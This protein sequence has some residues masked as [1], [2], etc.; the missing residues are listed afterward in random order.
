MANLSLRRMFAAT[1]L[2]LASLFLMPQAANA[3]KYTTGGTSPEPVGAAKPNPNTTKTTTKTTTST[4]KESSNLELIGMLGGQSVYNMYL[5]IGAIADNF[6][7]G[8]YEA[9]TAEQLLDVQVLF[10]ERIAEQFRSLLSDQE[11][12]ESD[13]EV[14]NDMLKIYSGLQ[15]QAKYAKA[16]INGD[17]DAATDFE[18]QRKK[19]WAA[20][21]E[22]LGLE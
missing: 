9:E 14:L 17:E 10:S 3:Q 12:V 21:S 11:L 2:A 16:F 18:S 7:S 8:N 15:K 5:V 13:K 19:N 6:A 4:K 22:L 1:S 20:I